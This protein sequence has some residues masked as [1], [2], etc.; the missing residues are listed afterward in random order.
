MALPFAL[1]ERA[2]AAAQ[3]LNLED[4]AITLEPSV[5]AA[6]AEVLW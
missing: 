3:I 6:C 5:P 2:V 1:D 4:S